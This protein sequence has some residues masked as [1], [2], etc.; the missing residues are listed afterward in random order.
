MRKIDHLSEPLS[1]EDRKY[2]LDRGF[3]T[4]VRLNDRKFAGREES[5]AAETNAPA[6][7]KAGTSEQNTEPP[8]ENGGASAE[9][10]EWVNSL[11]VEELKEELEDRDLAKSGNK[12]ELRS[13]L[14]SA[15]AGEE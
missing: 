1:N 10:T 7:D 14:L 13:R 5:V 11:D 9:D 15:M 12:S 4:R 3:T 6:Q 2:L 8:A